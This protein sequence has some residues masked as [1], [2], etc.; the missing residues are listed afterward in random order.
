MRANPWLAL[1]TPVPMQSRRHNFNYVCQS[2]C[3]SVSQSARFSFSF[4]LTYITYGYV[5]MYYTV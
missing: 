4:Q 3:Q 2:V 1:A 5:C